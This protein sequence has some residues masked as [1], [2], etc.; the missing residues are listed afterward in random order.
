MNMRINYIIALAIIMPLNALA[1]KNP[2]KTELDS[3]SYAAGTKLAGTLK[4]MGMK[5][6]DKDAFFLA[7]KHVLEGSK[8]LMENKI[9]EKYLNS[10]LA[11]QKTS[12]AA[13]NLADSEK[14]LG[15]NRK[16]EGVETL[17]SGLQYKI[18]T[19]GKGASPG[20]NDKVTVHYIGTLTNGDVFDSS[21][22]RGTPATFG[23]TQVIRGWTEALQLMKVGSKW[24]LYIH[25]DL[26]YGTS[27][28]APGGPNML[29]I[30]EVELLSIK[31][32]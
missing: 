27:P 18:L 4:Q 11:K 21:V 9:A 30:F 13:S 6:L 12:V 2:L 32:M 29:L 25:P 22:K 26:G 3:A 16:K 14:W 7:I 15:D 10:Y 5:E 17:A 1:Q 28:R 23:V 19:V 31:G 8:P 20:T 24:M